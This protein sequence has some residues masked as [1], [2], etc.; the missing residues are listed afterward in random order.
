MKIWQKFKNAK[1]AAGVK[2]KKRA[3]FTEPVVSFPQAKGLLFR[4]I[5]YVSKHKTGLTYKIEI[6]KAQFQ[7]T[8]P[9][10]IE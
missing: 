6:K 4:T 9:L 1:A 2:E 8:I 5:T 10:K 7:E 3:I